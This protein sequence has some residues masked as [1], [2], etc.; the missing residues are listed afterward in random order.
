MSAKETVIEMLQGKI[1]IWRRDGFVCLMIDDGMT[2]ATVSLNE[3]QA[4]TLAHQLDPTARQLND[5]FNALA[6]GHALEKQRLQDGNE[7]IGAWLAA[8][9]DDP[10]VCEEMKAD[11]RAWFEM[12]DTSH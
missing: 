5:T 2:T 7:R 10:T 6:V 3:G 11:I 9:L 4:E 12:K 1:K 8:A